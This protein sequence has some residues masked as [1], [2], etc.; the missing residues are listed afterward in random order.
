MIYQLLL[1][2]VFKFIQQ[3][4]LLNHLYL[5]AVLHSTVEI[6]RDGLIF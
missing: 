2:S 1:V 4:M 5:G 6:L 3:F